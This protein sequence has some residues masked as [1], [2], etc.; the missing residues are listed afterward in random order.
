MSIVVVV[1]TRPKESFHVKPLF[2]D[3]DFQARTSVSRETLERFRLYA[4]LLQKWQ[5]RS[6]LVGP[7]TVADL[8]QR[9]FLDSAQ[10]FSLI[11]EQTQTLVDLGSGA[12][13]PGLVLAM[14]GVRGVNLVESDQRKVAFL[15]EVSRVAAVPVKIHACR[16]DRV[17]PIKADVITARAL[18]ALPQLLEMASP[19]VGPET[20]CLF[21][22]GQNVEGELTE[23]HK[24]WS[25]Q[26]NRYPSVTDPHAT[27]LALREVR[28]DRTS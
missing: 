12:G 27:I 14:M 17:P 10:L 9:H 13:F 26:V 19:F 20:L 21:P 8:W 22:K 11:P 28:R 7:T 16:S 18:A 4:E 5:T 24:I 25:I 23:A 2:S 15:E 1:V 3:A 6:N